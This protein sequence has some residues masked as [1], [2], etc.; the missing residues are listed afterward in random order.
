LTLTSG[1]LRRYVEDL[2]LALAREYPEDSYT[3]LSDQT[4]KAP[5]NA[6][7]NLASA[8]RPGGRYWSFGLRRALREFRTDVFHGTNFEVPYFGN[9]PSI[10]TIHDLSPWKNP[11][12]HGGAERVRARTPW[13]IRLRR[14]SLILTVSEAIA[15]EVVS[16]FGVP[17]AM[18]RAVPLAASSLFRPVSAVQEVGQP[19]FLFVG[20]QEPRKNL[21]TLVEAWRSVHE[22]TGVELRVVGR[23]RADFV[24][25]GD[26]P[27]LTM[28][29]EVPDAELPQLYAN[30]VGF[31]YPTHYE[32]FGLPV[33]EAMQ[34]GCPVITSRDPAVMEVSGG[35]ALHANSAAEF[36]SAMVALAENT[37]LRRER[38]SAGIERALSFSWPVTARR[39]HDVYT[40]AVGLLD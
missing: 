22:Q 13:L 30:A 36:A 5:D 39:T 19:Y 38:R 7:A 12:W 32:G 11:E 18:V 1:G 33:L 24:P 31:V 23:T 20:T 14:A 8:I 9:T 10:L 27:G 6:P 37:E 29:G 3:L 28:M 25:L 2:A 26:Q 21:S 35:A 34:C 17:P 40:E 16:H 15:R 4:F